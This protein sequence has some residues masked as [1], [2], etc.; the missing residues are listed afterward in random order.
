MMGLQDETKRCSTKVQHVSTPYVLSSPIPW[1]MPHKIC[2]ICNMICWSKRDETSSS[3]PMPCWTL[4]SDLRSLE[5][6]PR[7]TSSLKVS[8][9][10]PLWRCQLRD[11]FDI[12]RC[13]LAKTHT[14]H[15]VSPIFVDRTNRW[16]ALFVAEVKAASWV[17][18]GM[19]DGFVTLTPGKA[20]VGLQKVVAKAGH[21]NCWLPQRT[22]VHWLTW[23]SGNTSLLCKAAGKRL[24]QLQ[25]LLMLLEV[26]WFHHLDD[27]AS[28]QLQSCSLWTLHGRANKN[29]TAFRLQLTGRRWLTKEGAPGVVH[30]NKMQSWK[31]W[32]GITRVTIMSS[33][34][35]ILKIQLHIF[36]HLLVYISN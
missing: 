6:W 33:L 20:V 22:L 7:N 24:G 27:Q 18:W 32:N 2:H 3:I 4:R 17:G 29:W 13:H 36:L 25:N 34:S 10:R 8:C 1:K 15:T 21:G 31:G 11:G 9:Q 23:E 5:Q 19:V 14:T 35:L 28:S 30:W 16:Q 12:S 26:V